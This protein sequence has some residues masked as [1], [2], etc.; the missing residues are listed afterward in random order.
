VEDSSFF[1]TFMLLD[2][3]TCDGCFFLDTLRDG[4]SEDGE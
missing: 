2:L 3:K 1:E 4:R